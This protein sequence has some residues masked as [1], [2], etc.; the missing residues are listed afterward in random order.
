MT[1]RAINNGRVVTCPD[2]ETETD[3]AEVEVVR[4]ITFTDETIYRWYCRGCN[5]DME[6]WE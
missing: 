3:L 1:E 6:V 4:L 5:N 2:C